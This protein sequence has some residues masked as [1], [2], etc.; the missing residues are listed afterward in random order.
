MKKV[1]TISL[2]SIL[3]S[4]GLHS[5]VQSMEKA[6]AS[7]PKKGIVAE[8]IYAHWS[9][10]ICMAGDTL[11]FKAYVLQ[12]MKFSDKSTC[13]Y[14]DLFDKRGY[15]MAMKTFPIVSGISLGQIEIPPTMSAGLYYVR[16]YT[17]YQ[18]N[19]DFQSIYQ[20]PV[21][22]IDPKSDK[23]ILFSRK[24]PQLFNEQA[25]SV[26]IIGNYSSK[27]FYYTIM[28]DEHC[29]YIDS[30]LS[31]YFISAA[32]TGKSD[33]ILKKD[34]PVSFLLPPS[35]ASTS[36]AL[37]VVLLSASGKVILQSRLAP[38]SPE[39]P[40]EIITDTLNKK[41]K[42]L[43]KWTVHVK[44]TSIATLSMTITDADIDSNQV[45]INHCISTTGFNYRQ[46]LEN[47]FPRI[48]QV[49]STYI[50][51]TGKALKS[52]DKSTIRN[53]TLIA[54]F[55][56][57]DSTKSFETLSIDTAGR[58]ELKNLFFYD[59][60]TIHFQLQE[61][62]RKSKDIELRFDR[63]FRPPFFIDTNQYVF[64]T[65]TNMQ[66]T[67][68]AD[69]TKRKDDLFSYDKIGTLKAVVVK[70]NRK[71]KVERMDEEYTNGAFRG[72]INAR[73]FDLINDNMALG[74]P[75]VL[76]YL[77]TRMPSVQISRKD[78][79]VTGLS[80]RQESLAFFL[81]EMPCD[82]DQI[83]NLPMSQIAYV[84][85]LPPPFVGA[86]LMKGAVS[87][88]TKTGSE[89]E[90]PEPK[91]LSEVVVSAKNLH[92][93]LDKAYATGLFSATA[94]HAIDLRS[95]QKEFDLFSYLKEKIPGFDYRDQGMSTSIL[96]NN[97]PIKIFIDEWDVQPGQLSI[98]RYNVNFLA[99]AKIIS[100][101]PDQGHFIPVLALYTRQGEDISGA[102]P[103]LNQARLPGFDR[104]VKQRPTEYPDNSRSD[105]ADNRINL[106]WNPMVHSG[107][108]LVKFYNNDFTKR[109]KV[110]IEGIGANGQLLH[111]EK[112]IE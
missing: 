15:L 86:F 10:T 69:V 110:I 79:K 49:D 70:A 56:T 55:N 100:S 103:G 6:L 20:V 43:N 23:A 13:L 76:E 78:G 29:P 106:F 71:T 107:E 98:Y 83:L 108:N 60:A 47:K 96:Y 41:E 4:P 109:F 31:L 92:K 5:Q 111:F 59:T 46:L 90:T 38:P 91:P 57:K 30:A 62:E 75:N 9:Q 44:D 45:C 89:L 74:T 17:K 36:Q 37:D 1:I 88:Y 102:L 3:F 24:I 14:V 94:D 50:T 22:V 105:Y 40:V 7:I 99:Y 2:L 51:L 25:D 77:T 12:G 34:S 101:F 27:G 63:F 68:L 18:L 53:K 95:S 28:A 16:A 21:S 8:N 104:I 81:N 35:P 54:F 52:S 26:M 80:Y 32:M 39:I 33:F 61:K 87:V 112:I 85:V 73:S 48:D 64:R 19:F 72:G 67:S 84:K 42:G 58:F 11:F 65:R 66:Q 93:K 82:V 97:K